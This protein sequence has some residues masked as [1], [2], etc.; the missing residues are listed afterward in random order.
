MYK[1]QIVVIVIVVAIMSY[2]YCLPIVGLT[3]S[4]QTQGH[5]NAA[6]EEK[7]PAAIVTVQMVSSAA[8]ITIGPALSEQINNTEGQLK[9]AANETEKLNLQKKLAKEWDDVNQPAP[10]AFCSGTCWR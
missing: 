1:K 10:A 3:T 2:L 8:K 4:P 6:A 5:T 9:N 7:R